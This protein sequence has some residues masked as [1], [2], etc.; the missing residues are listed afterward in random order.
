MDDVDGPTV[1]K[2]VYEALFSGEG[3]FT[4][5]EVIP[6]ALD[7][8]IRLLRERGVRPSRWAPYVHIGI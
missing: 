2:V 7:A 1:A 6:H 5:T 4:D 8:A 3:E